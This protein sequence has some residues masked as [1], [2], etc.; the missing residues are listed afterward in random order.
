MSGAQHALV[1]A[2]DEHDEAPGAALQHCE[3]AHKNFTGL[4][5]GYIETKICKKI[6]V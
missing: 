3:G 6:C 1:V 2:V 5:L 4:V